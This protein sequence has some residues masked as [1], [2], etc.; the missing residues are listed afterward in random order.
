MRLKNHHSKGQRCIFFY[1]PPNPTPTP[2]RG[3]ESK[4]LRARDEIQRRVK[5]KGREGKGQKEIRA[6]SLLKYNSE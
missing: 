3:K 6:I 4:G 5:Q 1:N 2:R